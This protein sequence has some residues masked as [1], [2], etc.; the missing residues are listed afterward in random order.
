[1]AAS[2]AS[3]RDVVRAIDTLRQSPDDF[4]HP[5]AMWCARFVA[6]FT[7]WNQLWQCPR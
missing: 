4:M 6:C 5:R 2:H 7:V 1:M 3:A